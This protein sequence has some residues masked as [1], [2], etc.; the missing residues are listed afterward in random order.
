MIPAVNQKVCIE[1]VMYGIVTKV[2]LPDE[3]LGFSGR[4]IVYT[5]K[6]RMEN[7]FWFHDYGTTV[8]PC[9]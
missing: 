2:Y 3:N 6:N 8:V 7:Y 9:K 1:G 5:P 4:F